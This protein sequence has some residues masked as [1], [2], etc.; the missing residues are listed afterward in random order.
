MAQYL[1][2]RASEHGLVVIQIG[3]DYSGSMTT[4]R[5][6]QWI[7]AL[8]TA[9]I[10]ALRAQGKPALAAEHIK[11]HGA[12]AAPTEPDPMALFHRAWGLA[13]ECDGYDK[14]AWKTAQAALVY[15]GRATPAAPA[16][17]HVPHA[18]HTS[19]ETEAAWAEGYRCGVLDA[20]GRGQTTLD[21]VAARAIPGLAE[22]VNALESELG[23]AWDSLLR[24]EVSAALL[25]RQPKA[26]QATIEPPRI[27]AGGP[28]RNPSHEAL[29]RLAMAVLAMIAVGAAVGGSMLGSA[30]A[31]MGLLAALVF[32]LLAAALSCADGIDALDESP[33]LQARRAWDEWGEEDIEDE[34]TAWKK[35]ASPLD[36]P[37][38]AGLNQAALA[39]VLRK[40]AAEMPQRKHA[41]LLEDLA[42]LA[43]ARES[44]AD[45]WA[46]SRADLLGQLSDGPT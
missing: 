18:E 12:P 21:R 34:I 45:E 2:A 6:L 16:S 11:Q 39:S 26:P 17:P 42:D 29:L 8:K 37:R 4:D 23:A 7:D 14:E 5:S 27:D 31:G 19:P 1:R 35:L 44:S 22:Y 25:E 41:S 20:P 15:A 36:T 3:S 13:K 40:L 24:L 43:E 10:D 32:G 46:E 9:T 28:V 30:G 33:S 38:V